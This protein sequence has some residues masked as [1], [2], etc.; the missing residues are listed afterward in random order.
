MNKW[1]LR[2]AS[3]YAVK[4][5]DR[6]TIAITEV[7]FPCLRK[8]YYDRTR[9]RLPTPAEALKVLGTEVHTLL[10]DVLKEEGW[11]IEVGVSLNL[12]EFKLVG[13]VDA[14]KG[15]EVIE[16]KTSNGLKDRALESHVLQLQAYMA[17]LH[18]KHGY[19]VY[20]DRASGRVRVFRVRPDRYALRI[21]IKRAK[22]LHEALANHRALPPKHAGAWCA[23][24]AYRWNCLRR[25]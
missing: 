6:D 8:A 19:I 2:A 23:L 11:D 1:L 18:A 12:G 14:V 10:Q 16:I 21:V 17:V 13:R 25:G 4:L 7:T 22:Q 24:C 5:L 15:D 20:I 9:R 3:R